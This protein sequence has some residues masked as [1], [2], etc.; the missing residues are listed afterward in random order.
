MAAQSKAPEPQPEPQ[1][2]AAPAPVSPSVLERMRRN[3]MG[4]VLGGLIVSLVVAMLLSILVPDSN[5]LLALVLLGALES[6]AVGF[7]VR[8]LTVERGLATQVT[9]FVL[10]AIGTHVLATTGVVN[11]AIGNLQDA[12]G[13]LLTGGPGPRGGAGSGLGWDDAL[14]GSLWTPTISTGAVIAGLV[15]A[16]IAGWGARPTSTD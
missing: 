11:T 9:A 8:T 3:R 13:A 12:I 1:P 14:L 10:A 15:A 16:I 2:A 5:V 7:A 4:A 6:A